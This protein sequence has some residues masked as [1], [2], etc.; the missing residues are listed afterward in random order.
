MQ[1]LVIARDYKD[2]LERRLACR[3][4]HIR[5]I[6]ELVAQGYF[7]HGGALLDDHGDMI[8]SVLVCSFE[9]EDALREQWLNHEPYVTGRV[10]E[11]IEILPY[12]VGPSFQ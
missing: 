6:D 5:V 3:H 10:W 2:A 9:S 1:F 4:E 8:G 11:T 12:R 7:H